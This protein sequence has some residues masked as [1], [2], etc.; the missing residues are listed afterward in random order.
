VVNVQSIADAVVGFRGAVLLFSAVH[1]GVFEFLKGRFLSVREIGS[2]LSFKPRPAEIFLDALTA[3]GFLIKREGR[4]KN[5]PVSDKYLVPQSPHSLA[6]NIRYQYRLMEDWLNLPTILRSGTP[7][8]GLDRRLTNAAFV[9]DYIQGMKEL[10]RGT[11]NQVS[12]HLCSFPGG[13]VLDV[14]GGHGH[15]LKALLQRRTDWRGALLDLPKTVRLARQFLA[16]FSGRVQFLSGNYRKINFGDN[17]FDLILM[18]HITHDES[19]RDNRFMFQKAARSLR[20]GGVLAVHDFL[21]DKSHT[22][23]A[24]SALFSVHMLTYT[25]KGRVYSLEEYR[26]M[27]NDARL[28]FMKVLPINKGAI[29]QSYLLVSRKRESAQ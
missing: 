23:P 8:Q 28:T 7:A 10:A 4:Y 9:N 3:Q 16:D 29:N 1:L 21:V 11:A 17:R 5:S 24:F 22:R 19:E 15:Y 27:L 18:S 12:A 13:S 2:E 26:R 25:L 14:G 20:P 6:N